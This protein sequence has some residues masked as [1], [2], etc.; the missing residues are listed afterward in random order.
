MTPEDSMDQ[1]EHRLL[2]FDYNRLWQFYR[3]DSLPVGR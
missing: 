3:D 1:P 2:W